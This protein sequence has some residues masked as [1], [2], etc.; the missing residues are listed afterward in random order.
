MKQPK[1]VKALEDFEH[2]K[3]VYA[4]GEFVHLTAEQNEKF[5]L[6]EIKNFLEEKGFENIEINKVKASIED[7]FIR[8][9]SI[10]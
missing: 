8:L 1:S 10:P 5:S 2:K 3:N 6:E 9:L 4:F 7:S